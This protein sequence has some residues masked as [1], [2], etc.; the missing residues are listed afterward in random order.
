MGDPPFRADHVGSL[1]RRAQLLRARAVHPATA[2]IGR[3]SRSIAAI[4]VVAALVAPNLARAQQPAFHP[5]LGDLMTA[6]VQPR[7]I[8]LGLAGNE[9]NWPYAAYELSELRE[10]FDDVAAIVPKY[11]D[12]SVPDL[13]AAT[14]RQPLA[15]I[16]RAIKAKDANRFTAAYGQLTAS[17]NA[18]HQSTGH[19]MIVIQ[20]SMGT[21]FPDQDF[22]PP[23]R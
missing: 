11:R 20:P 18:C 4:A 19:P 7:H 1:L 13:I 12:S 2:A 6:F 8:K 3:C 10:T 5:G 15:A 22:R 14:V 9:K 23:A 21:A 17:C 16:D